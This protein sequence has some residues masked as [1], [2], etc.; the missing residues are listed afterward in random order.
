MRDYFFSLFVSL[1]PNMD[2]HKVPAT[3]NNVLESRNPVSKVS[4]F[5][6]SILGLKLTR[7]HIRAEI[8]MITY[9]KI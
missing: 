5:F 7:K 1:Y 8:K 2:I 6:K 3:I 9:P 4:P